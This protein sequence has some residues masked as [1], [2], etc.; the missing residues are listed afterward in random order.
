MERCSGWER[1]SFF[2]DYFRG[3][4]R[5]WESLVDAYCFGKMN[6][7][8]ERLA[9]IERGIRPRTTFFPWGFS[10]IPGHDWLVPRSHLRCLA[11][12]PSPTRQ[13][14]KAKHKQMAERFPSPLP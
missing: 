11:P 9:Y 4:D 13:R 12:P 1:C 5:H 6:P 3:E 2:L 7:L 10:L 8:C 14:R